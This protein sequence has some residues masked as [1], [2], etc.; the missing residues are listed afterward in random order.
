MKE[1]SNSNVNN[2]IISVCTLANLLQVFTVGI[3]SAFRFFIRTHTHTHTCAATAPTMTTTA[4]A[5]VAEAVTRTTHIADYIQIN[6]NE[7]KNTIFFFVH[8]C[9]VSGNFT[10]FFYLYA[11]IYKVA[12]GS[13]G[14]VQTISYIIHTAHVQRESH[15]LLMPMC[16]YIICT[17]NMM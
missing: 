15:I 3:H 6:K 9:L 16:N 8:F 12:S 1:K 13:G 2:N 11:T 17:L 5:A 14:A 10:F 4:T 7:I